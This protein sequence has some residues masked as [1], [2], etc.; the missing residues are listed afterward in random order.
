MKK[1]FLLISLLAILVACTPNVESIPTSSPTSTITVTATNTPIVKWSVQEIMDII[2]ASHPQS[3]K[4]DPN[5]AVYAEFPEAIEQLKAMGLTALQDKDMNVSYLSAALGYPRPDS[6]LAGDVLITFPPEYVG[7]TMPELIDYLSDSRSQVRKYALI[8][9][10][11]VGDRASC[12]VGNISPILF[13]AKDST[14]RSASAIALDNIL[15]KGF[16]PAGYK[17]SADFF[18]T[19]SIPKDDPTGSFTG[20]ARIWWQNEGSKINWHPRYDLCDP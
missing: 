19:H 3:N 8:L 2:Q 1:S 15:K 12:A 16:V 7:T 17:I 4:Y 6:T 20:K 14:V 9:L 5:S 10:G 18:S 11:Y 13:L